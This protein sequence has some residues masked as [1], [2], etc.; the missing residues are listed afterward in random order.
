L[1]RIKF[2]TFGH[3]AVVLHERDIRKDLGAFSVLRDPDRKQAFLEALTDVLDRADI[4]VFAAV[5][6]KRKLAD[7]NRQA[8]PYEISLRFCLERISYALARLGQAGRPDTPLLT[9]ILCE[10]R[11]RV[12]DA[13]L[14][15]AFRRIC[16]GDNYNRSVLPFEPV[17]VDKKINSSGLQ[18]ADL[19]ARPI[20]LGQ[21]RPMQP[22][23]AWEIIQ[24]KM[25]RSRLGRI[26]GYGLKCFP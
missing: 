5:I 3:D 1:Q 14:E 9:H 15:L 11:G 24:T 2:A 17:F 6:D 4:T 10:A 20:G 19:V 25:D 7:R 23:R 22:N 12:E 26:E 13:Q 18:L 21:L 16:S 8:N